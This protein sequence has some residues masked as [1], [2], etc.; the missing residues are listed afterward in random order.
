MRMSY[1]ENGSFKFGN[2]D[3]YDTYGIQI[4][5]ASMPED[6]LLPSI[7][8]RKIE[9]PLRH[10]QY[11]YGAKY[12][13]ER[14]LVMK[15]FTANNCS[16][17][18]ARSFVREIAYALSKKNKIRVWNEPDRYYI[19]RVE[20]EISLEQKRDVGNVFTI[21]FTC[22]PF[23]YGNTV[24][25]N[26]VNNEITADYSGTASTPTIIEITNTGSTNVT[27]ITIT[28]VVRKDSY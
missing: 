7:R 16:D 23:A 2:I 28:Q 11:D 12:Y 22:D 3:M 10:G 17:T 24:S 15:C 21:E 19:G 18:E 13:S 1:V 8:P 6:L 26:F 20:K 5:D 27:G 25:K 4:L 14:S 9:I